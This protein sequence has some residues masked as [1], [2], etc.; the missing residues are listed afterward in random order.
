MKKLNVLIAVIFLI[1]IMGCAGGDDAPSLWAWLQAPSITSANNTTFAEGAAGTFT[2]TATGRPA[3]IL[4]FSGSLPNGVTFN[5][6]FPLEKIFVQFSHHGGPEALAHRPLNQ[7]RFFLGTHKS[8][9]FLPEPS[10]HAPPTAKTIPCSVE[11][12]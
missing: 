12:V 5:P 1:G 11:S 4:T 10:F 6:D 3:P 7:A 8:K 9:C 2:F